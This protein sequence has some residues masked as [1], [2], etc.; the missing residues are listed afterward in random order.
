MSFL[1]AFSLSF[2]F[3]LFGEVVQDTIDEF[4]TLWSAVFFGNINVLVDGD[5]C[6]NGWEFSQFR[7]SH[8]QDQTR[9]EE[10]PVRRRYTSPLS[11]CVS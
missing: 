8:P 10:L 7:N 2:L 4:F 1:S 9:P 3:Q 11:C 6:G 5:L